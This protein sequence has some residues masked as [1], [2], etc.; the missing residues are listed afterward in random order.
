MKSS[1]WKP[2]SLKGME[3]EAH[4][5]AADRMEQRRLMPT[6]PKAVQPTVRRFPRILNARVELWPRHQSAAV[7]ARISEVPGRRP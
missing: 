1:G 4:S 6:E 7:S 2:P 3:A 5:R